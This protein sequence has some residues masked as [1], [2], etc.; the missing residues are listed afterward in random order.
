MN[1]IAFSLVFLFCLLA[2]FLRDTKLESLIKK[3]WK[4]G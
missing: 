4:N 3:R 2:E 1:K